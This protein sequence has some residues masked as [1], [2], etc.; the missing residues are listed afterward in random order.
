MKKTLLSIATVIAASTSM[1]QTYDMEA[2]LTTPTEGASVA[3]TANQTLTFDIKNNGPDAFPS[4]DTLYFAYAVGTNIYSMDGT[5]NQADGTI[6]PMAIPD[7]FTLTSAMLGTTTTID[8]SGITTNT[9]VCALAL[10][11]NSAALTQAGDTRDPDQTNNLS[12]FTAT[13]PVASLTEEAAIVAS[14]YP[15]PASEVLNIKS[16]EV[17]KAVS[18]VTMD[19][20]VMLKSTSTSIDISTLA[21]GTYVYIVSTLSGNTAIGNFVKQ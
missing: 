6:L 21:P 3:G 16:A 9:Q 7:E 18:V 2:I 11:L 15:N 4:G 14:V 1:A 13:P 10:G 8:L 12:C 20:K 5:P 17:V 19:G